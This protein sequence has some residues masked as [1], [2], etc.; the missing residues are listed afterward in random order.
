MRIHISRRIIAKAHQRMYRG[1]LRRSELYNDSSLMERRN[2][3]HGICI[4]GRI[5]AVRSRCSLCLSGIDQIWRNRLRRVGLRT[6][7]VPFNIIQRIFAI[8]KRMDIVRSTLLLIEANHITIGHF[9]QTR[10]TKLASSNHLAI[11]PIKAENRSAIGIRAILFD[12]TDTECTICTAT[13]SSIGKDNCGVSINSLTVVDNRLLA[14][15][16]PSWCDQYR[17][18]RHISIPSLAAVIAGSNQN[19]TALTHEHLQLSGYII[20]LGRHLNNLDFTHRNL[21]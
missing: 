13:G 4:D 17:L 8:D 3:F 6:T 18:L 5:S 14:T 20:T 10:V 9:H 11:R 16:I 19:A 1:H 12:Q 15:S 21:A 2:L 7:N